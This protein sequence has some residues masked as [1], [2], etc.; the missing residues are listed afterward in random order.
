MAPTL[1][2]GVSCA[3]LVASFKPLKATVAQYAF[4]GQ[5]VAAAG[6]VALATCCAL[7]AWVFASEIRSASWFIY[8]CFLR[9]LGKT[10]TQ[11]DR[12]DAFYKGQSEYC[13]CSRHACD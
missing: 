7:V 12:L 1:A 2:Q 3:L 8:A 5:H 10:E 4:H 9:P 13:K 6:W 11:A